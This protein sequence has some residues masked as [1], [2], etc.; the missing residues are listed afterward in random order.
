MTQ[1]PGTILGGYGKLSTVLLTE[2][3]HNSIGFER[4]FMC[5]R[6]GNGKLWLPV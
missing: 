3:P 2:C 5:E 1:V 4:Y 6:S